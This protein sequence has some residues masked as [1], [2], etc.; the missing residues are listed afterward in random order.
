MSQEVK[1]LKQ[2]NTMEAMSKV[3][4]PPSRQGARK[5]WR[6]SCRLSKYHSQK[7]ESTR[8]K[9]FNR[10]ST[11]QLIVQISSGNVNSSVRA[12]TKTREH[13]PV[14]IELPRGRHLGSDAC[15]F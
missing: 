11:L 5:L 14:S 13:T 4:R 1:R 7:P 6:G 10:D 12:R 15:I 9:I 2:T 3:F 8:R